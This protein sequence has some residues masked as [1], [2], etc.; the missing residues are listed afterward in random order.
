[1]LALA[2]LV[3]CATLPSAHCA[4]LLNGARMLLLKNKD[5]G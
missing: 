1:M 2:A 5:Y 4:Q 3:S